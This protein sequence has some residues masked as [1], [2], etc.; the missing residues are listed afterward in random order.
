MNKIQLED[1]QELA[2]EAIDYKGKVRYHAEVHAYG[3]VV[4]VKGIDGRSIEVNRATL[5]RKSK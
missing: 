5:S 3:F 2:I 4:Y 1:G